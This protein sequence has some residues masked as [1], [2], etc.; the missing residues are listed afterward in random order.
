MKVITNNKL[1]QERFN[2]FEIEYYDKS[3][4][5]ILIICRDLLHQGYI[6]LSHPLSGSIKP[7]ETPYKSI[8]IEEGFDDFQSIMMIESAIT[9]AS[10]MLNESK[11]KV[12]TRKLYADFA[13]IDYE[14]IHSAI[15]SF[16]N[17]IK[18]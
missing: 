1:V 8:M 18:Q 12:Y 9:K 11:K 4:L 7:D 3:L 2:E 5:D 16:K 15:D 6:L 14:L 13:V 10:V 17:G